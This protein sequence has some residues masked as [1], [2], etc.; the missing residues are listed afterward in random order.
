MPMALAD[1]KSVR[2]LFNSR[3]AAKKKTYL[4]DDT[5]HSD[6]SLQFKSEQQRGAM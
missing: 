5:F 4:I 2:S 1:M 3:F 6:D